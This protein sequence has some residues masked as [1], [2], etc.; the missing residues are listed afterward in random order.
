MYQNEI[1]HFVIGSNFLDKSQVYTFI[2]PASTEEIKRWGLVFGII[3]I[4]NFNK[5]TTKSIRLIFENI[6]NEYYYL[7]DQSAQQIRVDAEKIFEDALKKINAK[8]F[9]FIKIEKVQINP[10]KFSITL[11]VL[12]GGIIHLA[13]IGNNAAFLIHQI[14]NKEYKII[15][16]IKQAADKSLKLN[17]SKIFSNLIS[18]TV[19]YNDILMLTN[20]NMVNTISAE[21]IK[22]TLVALPP[23][24]ASENFK[25]LLYAAS[26]DS[27][28]GVIIVKSSVSKKVPEKIKTESNNNTQASMEKLIY[29]QE[30]TSEILVPSLWTNIRKTVHSVFE[31]KTKTKPKTKKFNWPIKIRTYKA[32]LEPPKKIDSAP[33]V[34]PLPL[35]KQVDIIENKQEPIK[36][37]FEQPVADNSSYA[38]NQIKQ[39]DEELNVLPDT[40]I[41]DGQNEQTIN[42]IEEQIPTPS[43]TETIVEQ[44]LPPIQPIKNEIFR[45]FLLNIYTFTTKITQKIKIGFAIIYQKVINYFKQKFIALRNYFFN[46]GLFFKVTQIFKNILNNFYVLGVK[47]HNQISN[48]MQAFSPQSKRLLVAFAVVMIIF[49]NSLILINY[50]QRK[51]AEEKEYTLKLE[52]IYTLQDDAEKIIHNDEDGAKSILKNALALLMQLPDN[53]TGEKKQIQEEINNKLKTLARLTEH[54]TLPKIINLP[55]DNNKS[56]GGLIKLADT[57]FVYAQNPPLLYETNLKNIS[58]AKLNDRIKTLAPAAEFKNF[59]LAVAKD[60]SILFIDANNK[61]IEFNTKDKNWQTI[62]ISLPQG[63]KSMQIYNRNLYLLT[64]NQI[65]KSSYSGGKFD[66]P[67]P[68]LKEKGVNLDNVASMAI[69]GSIYVAKN[70][71]EILKFLNGMKQNFTINAIDPALTDIDKIYT[72]KDFKFIY[73]LNSKE[74]RVIILNKEGKNSG[75]LEIQHGL[76]FLN[77]IIDLSVDEANKKIYVLGDFAIYELN[78]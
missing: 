7:A 23:A 53:A 48:K 42:N 57:L 68:W 29:T 2:A 15:D 66:E 31:Q 34:A 47:I 24:E 70:N 50:R 37:N 45:P 3:E 26:K 16:I 18:G 63:V 20:Q 22:K 36:E 30:K 55:A 13:H 28:F 72:S 60:S 6:Q 54:N 43:P 27:S 33:I 39:I 44:P 40:P 59:N 73:I 17:L 41:Q 5:L 46:L 21:K 19:G 35:P 74:K 38:E 76:N 51:E 71:G 25:T 49:I 11:G 77:N 1:S 8:F 4:P 67:T 14:P 69:D 52:Q 32:I 12:H 58:A 61:L 75:K 78:L 10:K 64:T 62:K 56:L 9:D 65:Y